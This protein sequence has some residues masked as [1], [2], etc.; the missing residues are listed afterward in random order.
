MVSIPDAPVDIELKYSDY[1]LVYINGVPVY[2]FFV[3]CI[4]YNALPTEANVRATSDSAPYKSMIETLVDEPGMFFFKNGGIN[5]IAEDVDL[6]ESKNIAILKFKKDFGI[7][8][9]GHTQKAI[10][11]CKERYNIDDEAIVRVEV[12]KWDLQNLTIADLATAKNSS[13]NVK[14]FSR[15]NKMGL[16]EPIKKQMK[17]VYEQKITW[18][19]NEPIEG[20][21]LSS[22]ELIAILNMFDIK[23][24]GKNEQPNASANGSGSVFD[25]WMNA[26]RSDE[27]RLEDVYPLVNDILDLYEY[28]QSTFNKDIGNGLTKRDIIKRP[29]KGSKSSK[30]IF[31]N[32]NVEFVLPKQILMPMLGCLRA[33]LQYI[34][35]KL[36]WTIPPRRLFDLTKKELTTFINNYLKQN[37]INKLSKDPN[38]WSSLYNIVLIEIMRH[39]SNGTQ[40]Q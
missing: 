9:G 25:S 35:G 32:Q 11:D 36:A 2:T 22:V 14:S 15:A 23:R 5:V 28:I 17:P 40:R 12:I 20:K 8:N 31:T 19:E 3:K 4:D 26:N 18:F 7:L 16:F 27:A 24:Y 33:D 29:V 39:E 1:S 38:A 37:D 34:D 21:P 13:C 6:K 10:L 30:T